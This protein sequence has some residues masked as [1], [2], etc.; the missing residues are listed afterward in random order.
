M[1]VGQEQRDQRSLSSFHISQ[2]IV[3]VRHISPSRG[4][5]FYPGLCFIGAL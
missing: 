5:F 4:A 2:Q 1:G 3:D